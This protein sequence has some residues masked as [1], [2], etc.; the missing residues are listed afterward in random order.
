M[1]TLF[2]WHAAA[3]AL[4]ALAVLTELVRGARATPRLPGLPPLPPGELPSVTVVI[5]ARNEARGVEAALRSVL[6][7]RGAAVDVVVVNDRSDDGTGE[8]LDRMAAGEPRLRVVHVRE[9]PPGWLGKN[10]ALHVGAAAARGE[11]LLFTDA[12][13]HMAPDTLLRA[14]GHM[15]REG[16]DHVAVAPRVPMPGT[17]LQ[18]FGVTFILFFALWVRPRKVR[19]P[20][21]SAHVGIGAFNLVRADTYR[22]VGMHRQIAMRPDDDVKLGKLLKKNG[23][24]QDMVDGGGMV[25][26]EWYASVGEAVRGLR[27]NGFAGVD[28]RISVVLFATF[29][30]LTF[31]VAP[32]A[33]VLAAGGTARLLYALAVAA[34]L[35]AFAGGARGQ[36]TPA[37]HGVLF[38]VTTLLFLFVLWNA[39]VY[40]LV[41][42]GIEWRGTHYPLA[43]LRANRV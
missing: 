16:L 3:A 22:R 1:S 35:A 25:E 18:A 42:R 28:Y 29:T 27:K 11:L 20:R 34:L 12:D 24:R 30:H 4:F 23:A 2:T 40:A 14:A 41:H 13:V 15:R 43:E 39:T 38:P 17:L 7:L 10:H 31:F 21:S 8:I 37:W 19:D 9:L 32:F 33:G 36:G 5:A 6:E 26:V